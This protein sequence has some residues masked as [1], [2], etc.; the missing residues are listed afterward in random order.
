MECQFIYDDCEHTHHRGCD[1]TPPNVGARRARQGDKPFVIAMR[2]A[3]VVYSGPM[4]DSQKPTHT[5]TL[6]QPGKGWEDFDED[7]QKLRAD[8]LMELGNIE[9]VESNY[10]GALKNYAEAMGLYEGL[11]D[12]NGL[13]RI[14]YVVGDIHRAQ[15]R[16]A[17]AETCFSQASALFRQVGNRRMEGSVLGNLAMMYQEQGAYDHAIEHSQQALSINRAVGNKRAEGTVLGHLG[18]VYQ[19][20]GKY[21][22]AIAHYN[23]ALSIKIEVGDRLGEGIVLGHLG[24]V[25]QSMGK[26]N[27]AI[28]HLHQALAVQ[29]EIGNKLQEGG[30]LGNL[31]DV[32][33]KQGRLKEAAKHLQTAI[34]RCDSIIPAAAGAFQGSLALIRAKQG[35]LETARS[36]LSTGE[37][38]VAPIPLELGKFLCKKGE[39]HLLSGERAAAESAYK[40]AQGIAKELNVKTNSQLV[41]SI[42][43]LESLLH[44]KTTN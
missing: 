35:D 34:R 37:G 2:S 26:H 7:P 13:A 28:N 39:I 11:G 9:R 22:E 30:V 31:G 29:R 1:K 4:G 41:R 38:L 6:P 36:L 27:E 19:S 15:S 8:A 12:L 16:Y 21:A 33:L 42:L 32:L 23:Q 24:G 40:Q 20:L 5:N 43:E 10:E 25:Y 3:G 17:Q 14:L 44:S 18:G